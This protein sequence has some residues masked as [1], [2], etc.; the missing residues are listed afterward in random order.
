MDKDG[1]TGRRYLVDDQAVAPRMVGALRALGT[2]CG[3]VQ[4]VALELA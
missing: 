4:R 1:K 3:T 2:S